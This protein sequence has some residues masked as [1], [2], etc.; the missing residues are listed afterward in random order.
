MNID[1]NIVKEN[2]EIKLNFFQ[3][4]INQLLNKE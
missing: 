2:N 4:A 3:F 1:K